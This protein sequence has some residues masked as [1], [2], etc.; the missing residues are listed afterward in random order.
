MCI[1]QNELQERSK[2]ENQYWINIEIWIL[3]ALNWS[4]WSKKANWNLGGFIF[5][6]NT[7]L[8]LATKARGLQGCRPRGRPRS[9]ITCSQECEECKE[10]EGMNPHTPKWTPIVGVGVQIFN[11]ISGVKTHRFRKFFI[12]LES[13]W[14]LDV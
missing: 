2:R 13:Y 12:L 3:K 6:R 10:C 4:K 14:N 8:G 5:C 9:C 11:A 1:T 7:N